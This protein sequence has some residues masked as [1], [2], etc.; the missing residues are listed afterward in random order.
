MNADCAR[1]G[2][3][4]RAHDHMA[5]PEHR[6]CYV[7]IPAPCPCPGYEWGQEPPDL[8]LVGLEP[9]SCSPAMFNIEDGPG[10][11]PEY[12]GGLRSAQWEARQAD[13]ADRDEDYWKER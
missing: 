7:E 4:E 3:P 2:C 8:T 10:G 5:M 12:A 6:H 9:A 13:H 11:D 1:C